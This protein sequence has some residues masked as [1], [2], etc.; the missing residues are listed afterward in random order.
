MFH[1][2]P[3]TR[4]DQL[5]RIAPQIAMFTV[6]CVFA[7]AATLVNDPVIS[8]LGL[9]SLGL[10]LGMAVSSISLVMMTWHLWP[11]VEHIT[12]WKRVEELKRQD[13]LAG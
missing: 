11:V 4:V 6:L 13:E 2:K 1:Q 10:F 3:P 9:V 12:D 5:K 7:A 8:R